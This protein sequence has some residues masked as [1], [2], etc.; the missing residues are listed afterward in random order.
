MNPP[1]AYRGRVSDPP[2]LEICSLGNDRLFLEPLAVEHSAEMTALLDDPL[3]HIYTGGEPL[4]AVDLRA[5]YVRQAVGQSTDGSERWL[6]WI[7]RRRED[8]RAVGYVQATATLANGQPSADVAWVIGS[9]FQHHGY[10][11]DA[12][13][14]MVNWLG[15]QGVRVITAHIHPGHQAS[16]AVASHLGLQPTELIVDG[17][18]RWQ[19]R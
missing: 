11:K 13:Q 4:S 2:E 6:N 5:Q 19:N 16:S 10:A 8:H 18:I 3:L 17:E 12:A 14:L 7:V 15:L 1:Q 9:R